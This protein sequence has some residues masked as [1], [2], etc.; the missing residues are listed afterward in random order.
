MCPPTLATEEASR[1][2]RKRATAKGTSSS[3]VIAV[4]VPGPSA[5][6][7]LWPEQH[8]REF[9]VSGLR[10]GSGLAE[11]G[12]EWCS[13]LLAREVD[14]LT[15]S[16]SKEPGRLFRDVSQAVTRVPTS[17][18]IDGRHVSPTCMPRAAGWLELGSSSRFMLGRESLLLQ[19]FPLARVDA[20]VFE[21]FL[22][23]DLAGNAMAFPVLLAIVMASFCSISWKTATAEDAPASSDADV[24]T[25][26][27]VFGSMACEG[28]GLQ[29]ARV[30]GSQPESATREP[31]FPGDPGT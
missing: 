30:E 2:E 13:F 22:M 7:V 15:Y 3:Q 17:F 9:A 31:G 24:A 21:E 5:S 18:T 27:S 1:R 26:M 23:Q 16:R 29:S 10:W 12:S 28:P 20:D 8:A 11:G 6:A 4:A 14:A 19:G 25:A